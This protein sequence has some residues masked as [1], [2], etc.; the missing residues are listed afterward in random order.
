MF[1]KADK[2]PRPME[3]LLNENGDFYVLS[4]ATPIKLTLRRT[5]LL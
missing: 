3:R 4:I 5:L 2:M 1:K